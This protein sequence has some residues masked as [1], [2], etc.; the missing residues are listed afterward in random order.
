VARAA[1]H[2]HIRRTS[3][4][5]GIPDARSLPDEYPVL[6]KADTQDEHVVKTH[7]LAFRANDIAT[8]VRKRPARM[9]R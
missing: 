7:Y 3:A 8:E 6:R 5:G 1:S 2:H 9:I 4:L